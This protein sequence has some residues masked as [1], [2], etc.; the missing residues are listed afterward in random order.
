MLTDRELTDA[1][2][3]QL[4]EGIVKVPKSHSSWSYQRTVDFK[5]CIK[6]CKKTISKARCSEHELRSAIGALTS[7]WA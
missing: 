1:L 7:F 3:R 4:K 2:R 6:E 5:S